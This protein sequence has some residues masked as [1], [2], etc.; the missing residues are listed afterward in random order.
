MHFT[1]L[2]QDIPDDDFVDRASTLP[3]PV[4]EKLMREHQLRV[5]SNL[6][7]N[8]LS[9]VWFFIFRCQMS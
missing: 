1:E 7:M 5:N 2:F 8:R 6:I 9:A 4:C 3:C